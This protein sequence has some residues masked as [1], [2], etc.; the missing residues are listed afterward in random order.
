[1]FAIKTSRLEGG[2]L[3]REISRPTKFFLNR[4]AKVTAQLTGVHYRRSPFFQ[5]DLGIPCLVTVTVPGSIEGH[6]LI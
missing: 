1:M 2:H 3:P 4:E 6:M 5:G